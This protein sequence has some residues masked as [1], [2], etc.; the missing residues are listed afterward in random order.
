MHSP[1]KIVA[2]AALSAAAAACDQSEPKRDASHSADRSSAPASDMAG[3][4]K[5]TAAEAS[6]FKPWKQEA[7]C[8]WVMTYADG[9]A[10]RATISGGDDTGVFLT[11]VDSDLFYPWP[12]SDRIPVSLRLDGDPSKTVQTLANHADEDSSSVLTVMLEQP[13]RKLISS[14]TRLELLRNGQVVLELP[15]AS[16]PTAAQLEACDPNPG[17]GEFLEP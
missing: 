3:T 10:H 1:W 5:P 9:V 11:L 12:V 4:V 14:A 13:A 15:M 16:N 7:R 8:Y 6:A 2:L 17:P